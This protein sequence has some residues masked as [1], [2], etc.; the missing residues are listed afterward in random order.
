MFNVALALVLSED[1]DGQTVFLA[2][3][4]RS[5]ADI[6][7]ASL[8]GMIVLVIRKADR[9]IRTERYRSCRD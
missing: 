1:D 9:I 4:V 2:K 6:V 5:A 3:P 8:I 7:I